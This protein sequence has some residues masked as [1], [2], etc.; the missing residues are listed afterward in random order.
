MA[1]FYS[2]EQI[3]STKDSNRIPD[4]ATLF[5]APDGTLIWARPG[6][7]ADQL[8]LG[9]KLPDGTYDR[10]RYG[11]GGVYLVAPPPVSPPSIQILPPNYTG[12]VPPRQLPDYTNIA[13]PP[14]PVS[15]GSQYFQIRVGVYAPPRPA[16]LELIAN[17]DVFP[18][19]PVFSPDNIN[20]DWTL[21]IRPIPIALTDS[22]I[23]AARRLLQGKIPSYFDQDRVGK[24]L[25]N[26]GED[27]QMPIINWQYDPS[28]PSGRTILVKTYR[29][30]PED[31][32]V[33]SELWI[34]RE[35]SPSLLDQLFVVFIPGEGLRVYLRPPN[36]NINVRN[37]DGNEVN[38]VTLTS[39]FTTSS[40][41]PIKPNDP[42]M[43][44]WFI[45]SLEGAELNINYTNFSNFVFYSSAKERVRAF[46]Q[47]LAT[48][49]NYDA[50]IAQQSSSIATITSG[51]SGF[52]S[53]IS[54]PT[55][56]RIAQQREDLL[57][58]FDG[59]ERH[60]YYASG[61]Q[62]SSS[63]SG[64]E[65]DQLYFMKPFEWP[66]ISGSVISVVS[67]SNANLYPVLVG[68]DVLPAPEDGGFGF[69]SW[70]D[71]VEYIAEEY[72]RQNQNRLVNNLP[73]YLVNDPR[74]QDFIKLLDLV[75][76]H[77]DILKAYADAM[78]DIY[79]RNSNPTEGLSVDMIWNIAEAFGINLPN[80]YAVK[81]LVD[82]TTGEIGQVSPKVYRQVA[83]ETWKRFLHN[84]IFLTKAKGT[85]AALRG[86]LNSYGILPTTIQIRETATP[87]FYTTQSYEM[88]E[89]QTNALNIRSGSYVQIPWSGSGLEFINTVQARF[90]T[91]T[92]TRS[93]LYNVDNNWSLQ[94]IPVSRSFGYLAYISGTTVAASSSAFPIFD[95]TFYSTTLQRTPTSI[96][97]WLQQ[98]DDD[99]DIVYDS[100]VTSSVASVGIWGSGTVLY[101]GSS[102]TVPVAQPFAG[103]VDEFRMWIEVLSDDTIDFHAKYPGLYNG[104]TVSSA[105]DSLP[106]R[107]SFNKPRN[108][109]SVNPLNRFVVNETPYIRVTGR[110]AAMS[111]FTASAFP[112][113]TGYPNSMEVITRNVLRFAP[114][115]GG[116][117]YVTNKVVIADP[118]IF[119]TL[120]DD[121]GSGVPVLSHK[122]SM[123]TIEDKQ[124]AVQSNN[125]VGF[126]FSITD[127]I[128]DSII[129][130]VGNVDIQDYIGDPSDLYEVRYK[131]LDDINKLYWS[132][133]AYSYN[134]NS[135]VEFVDTLLQ[136]LFKQAKEFVPARAKLLTGI[137]LEP[138]I[139][140]R[141]KIQWKKINTSGKG[142][143]EENVNPTLEADP[144]TSQPT[145]IDASFDVYNVLVEQ[146]SANQVI[147]ATYDTFDARYDMNETDQPQA[148]WAAYDV[149]YEMVGEEP[150]K[151]SFD[152][153][154][155]STRSFEG[156]DDIDTDFLYIDDNTSA[157]DYEKFL[158]Q[159]FRATSTAQIR[160]D[161]K[162]AFTQLLVTYRPGS[163]VNV[164]TGIN[165]EVG[166][167]F[168]VSPVEPYI[169]F[170]NIG[171]VNYFTQP[172]GIF[173]V[174]TQRRVRVGENSLTP[175]GVWTKGATYTA[176]QYVTQS[177]QVGAAEAGNGFE[178]VCVTPIASGSFISYN[179]PSLD[180]NNWRR[181]RYTTVPTYDIRVVS[182]VN[183][184]LQLVDSGS[185][186][187]PFVGYAKEHYRF[188]RDIRLGTLRRIWLGCK[189][190]DDTT[191]DGGP[192]V[193]VI[194]SAGDVLVVSTG[195]EPV[196]RTNDN[197]GPILD[198]R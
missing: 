101:L 123:V 27:Y 110:S 172:D 186:Y 193:E 95:G 41:D 136:P 15:N 116:S 151:A 150:I 67:A 165:P 35:L 180:T 143:F 79:D 162:A 129:R 126:F 192:A 92:V 75:G 135:F 74:S 198:V 21:L 91:T 170:S 76:H 77:F 122:K 55:V 156:I 111:Q 127:A 2:P 13:P 69:V 120:S 4:D 99:G 50:V 58:S 32:Q 5:T 51:L 12:P 52:T 36:R 154:D 197:A 109:G 42:I 33:F 54:Y 176:G 30:L 63:F 158:L 73:E 37:L 48:I 66:K 132:N 177:D 185:G 137:V 160:E 179:P 119:R 188:R 60:L 191:F 68:P 80:Q 134:Y 146:P 24:T 94:L 14:P 163:R 171:V 46:K 107:L 178:F 190:S 6:V 117:Q 189:Q 175:A 104:N 105:R 40:F 38:N 71:A 145:T 181:V 106:V 149:I 138:H 147:V 8:G 39:L 133:Y 70:I 17:L 130:S 166:E 25:L 87:S 140:E 125:V 3:K 11:A 49:E 1:T 57:R 65:I 141:N 72:D 83:A 184:Q 148:E 28:E 23:A 128:N 142:T 34:D 112:N 20:V 22:V 144:F 118:P 96:N 59:F 196:Q 113:E 16:Q 108:L 155:G 121:S 44:E 18:P 139:L 47:K 152:M 82:Y 174:E 169:D 31:A 164:N 89:E 26:F 187:V 131:N 81:A 124:N 100:Y 10:S 61:S 114:N 9:N 62:Y 102:G 97:L 103:F 56:I 182:S 159:R 29:P 194:P 157:L 195:A 173:L 53:S 43:N 19:I 85:K 84:H 64:E 45:T 78:P 7:T 183:G 93:A 168:Y 98:T 115:A 86:L 88:I 161:D 167:N 90:A 153:F